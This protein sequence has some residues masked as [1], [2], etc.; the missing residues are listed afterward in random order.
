[1]GGEDEEGGVWGMLILFRPDHGGDVEG[2]VGLVEG[3]GVVVPTVVDADADGAVGAEEELV[4]EAVGVF[5]ADWSGDVVDEEDS[6]RGE[7]QGGVAL[8]EDGEGAA[9]V[10]VLA[11]GDEVAAADAEGCGGSLVDEVAAG[12]GG[13]WSC[14]IQGVHRFT[15][16]MMWSS[17]ASV[18]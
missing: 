14:W 2:E 8:A 17:W 11:E 16:S 18:R 6:L 1:M 5:A 15:V 4:A 7:G 9:V 12:D 13:R 10:A 3:D